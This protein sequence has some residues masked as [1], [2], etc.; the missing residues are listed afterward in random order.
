MVFLYLLPPEGRVT[1]ALNFMLTPATQ[2]EEDIV[3]WYV[4][5]APYRNE[6]RAKEALSQSGIECFVPMHYTLVEK[7]G[8]KT[9]KYM[10]AIHNLIF[11]HA[12]LT[13][14]QDF[15]RYKG[16]IQYYV[17]PSRRGGVAQKLWVPDRQMKD[18]I[19]ICEK[20]DDSLRYMSPDDV[21]IAPGTRV[22]VHGGPFDGFEGNFV[23]VAG[24]RNRQLVVS[25]TNLVAASISVSADLV[26]V[27][28]DEE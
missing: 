7:S 24:K 28:P 8:I 12:P 19:N 1:D 18:F 3:R 6:L 11:V 5:S 17:M 14:I 13:Q 2:K 10:P 20:G 9:R 25:I 16:I 21:H 22:R 27:I 26:E 23:K 15:K 4:M